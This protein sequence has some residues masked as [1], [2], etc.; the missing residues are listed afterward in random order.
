[1]NTYGTNPD[2]LSGFRSEMERQAIQQAQDFLQRYG[3]TT[4]QPKGNS[5]VQGTSSLPAGGN[6]DLVTIPVTAIEHAENAPVDAFRTFLYPNFDANE[7]YVKKL[8]EDGKPELLKF[9]IKGSE[10]GKV[11]EDITKKILGTLDFVN[12]RMKA[13]EIKLEHK[14]VCPPEKKKEKESNPHDG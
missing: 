11:F 14:C 4:H 10:I 8:G 2:Y 13:I 1:M 9:T 6:N 3:I 7:I 5:P 12:E